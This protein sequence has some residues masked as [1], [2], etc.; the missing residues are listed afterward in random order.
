M[1]KMLARVTVVAGCLVVGG[2]LT[3]CKSK[4]KTKPAG[5]SAAAT[6]GSATGDKIAEPVV[7][8]W[9]L[10]VLPTNAP[11]VFAQWDMPGRAQAWQGAWLS[12]PGVGFFLAVEVTGARVASW[13]GKV[14]KTMVF[15]LESPCSAKFI[16]RSTAGESSSTTHFTVKDGKLLAGLGDAGSRKG[17]A[18]IVCASN[19]ILALDEA[20][21]CTQFTPSFGNYSQGPGQCAFASKAGVEVFTATIAGAPLEL[22][23]DGDAIY[24]AQLGKSPDQGFADF[25]AAKAARH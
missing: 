19:V 4:T 13:D 24:S 21:T 6:A 16:E 25:A 3:A 1:I 14:E 15:A 12:Q 8:D 22:V 20:G 5:G 7:A 10:T 17:K 9:R 11:E 2:T 23:V 18:A